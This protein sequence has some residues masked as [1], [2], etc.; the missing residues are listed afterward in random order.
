M[1]QLE[2]ITERRNRIAHDADRVGRG[3]ATLSVEEVRVDIRVLRAVVG[4]IETL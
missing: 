1:E 4:A 2:R 3:R